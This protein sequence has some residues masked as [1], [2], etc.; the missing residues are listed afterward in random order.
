MPEVAVLLATYNGSRYIWEQIRSLADNT[1]PFTL[2]W[3]DDKST[4]DTETAVRKCVD[5]VKITLREWRHQS[6]L[7]VPGT[8]FYLLECV[9]ADIYLFCDQDD[10]WEAGKL[11]A[12]V[13]YLQKHSSAPTLAF[14]GA[15]IFDQDQPSVFKRPVDFSPEG[16]MARLVQKA[17]LFAFMPGCPPAKTQGFTRPLRDLF[18]LHKDVAQEYAAYHDWWIYDIATASADLALLA[19]APGVLHRRH[20]ENLCG[21]VLQSEKRWLYRT[22]HQNQLLRKMAARHAQGLLMAA[23]TLP[24]GDRLDR[25]V[26]FARIVACLERRQTPFAALRLARL[27]IVHAGSPVSMALN[28]LMAGVQSNLC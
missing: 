8:F 4:D 22:W 13:R 17:Q 28:C 25:M 3:L 20:S 19:E 14:T 15:S 12:T 1:T 16:K 2:H 9:E 10:I 5:A 26:E 21:K 23:D 11:D 7:G 6:H 27:G 24:P 18:L